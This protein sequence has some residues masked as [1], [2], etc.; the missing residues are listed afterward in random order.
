MKTTQ[1]DNIKCVSLYKNMEHVYVGSFSLRESF[2]S[3]WL[4]RECPFLVRWS[5]MQAGVPCEGLSEE[6]HCRG[7]VP[8]LCVPSAVSPNK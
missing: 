4:C 8:V 3:G 5:L 2:M 6:V 7:A 1:R